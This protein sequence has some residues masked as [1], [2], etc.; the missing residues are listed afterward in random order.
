L[1]LALWE[2]ED[3][4]PEGESRWKELKYNVETVEMLRLGIPEKAVKGFSI[5]KGDP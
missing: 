2:E 5:R 4:G 3:K 1:Y